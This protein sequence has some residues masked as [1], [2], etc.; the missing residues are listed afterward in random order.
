MKGQGARQRTFVPARTICAVS[1][2]VLGING[3]GTDVF[4]QQLFGDTPSHN[5]GVMS[6]TMYLTVLVHQYTNFTLAY[7]QHYTRLY[8]VLGLQDILQWVMDS[9]YSA[10]FT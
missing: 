4:L 8:I 6:D 3:P 7:I 10:M 9:E 1:T 2:L 5:W